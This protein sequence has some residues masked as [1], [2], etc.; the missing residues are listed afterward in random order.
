MLRE[1][2]A[3]QGGFRC[4]ASRRSVKRTLENGVKGWDKGNPT[5]IKLSQQVY[6]EDNSSLL[7]V[8]E[9]RGVGTDL[10]SRGTARGLV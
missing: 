1:K 8:P 5:K 4:I 3:H 9:N 10:Q 7:G 2:Q 6:E